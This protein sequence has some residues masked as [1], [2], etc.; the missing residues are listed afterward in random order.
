MILVQDL[1]DQ[2]AFALDAEGSD[3]YRDNEDYIPA[4][5]AAMNWL[6]TVVSSAYGQN[7]IGEEFF[8][9][10]TL[11][12]I[13][14][15]NDKSRVSLNVFPTNVWTI[16]AVYVNPETEQIQGIPTP[17]TNDVKRSYHLPNLLHVSS[18]LDCKRLSIEEWARNARNPFE[19]GYDGDQ[20]CDNLKLY[21]YLNPIT[22]N[23]SGIS[24]T[25]QELEVRP[26]IKNKEVT[27]FWVKKPDQ[28]S[29]LTDVINFPDSLLNLLFN[30]ALNYISYKQ[31]DSTNINGVSASDI[32]QL[33]T[34]L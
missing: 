21:A 25:K 28:V 26:S 27:I 3:H 19:H 1:R 34:V 12:G 8:R 9:E 29:A 4:I 13:F 23:N 6:T 30:K 14:L 31:G 11:S 17:I 33:L 20:I 16:L 22:Y 15:T 5:N 10:L 2:L 32:Q 18:E 24:Q 7:K